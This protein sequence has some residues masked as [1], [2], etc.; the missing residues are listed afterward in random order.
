MADEKIYIYTLSRNNIP[1]YVGA[2]T[3]I[4]NRKKSHKHYRSNESGY[5]F[6][7]IDITLDE[8]LEQYWVHQLQSWGFDLENRQLILGGYIVDDLHKEKIRIQTKLSRG[9]KEQRLISSNDSKKRYE[10]IEARKKHSDR[11]KLWWAERKENGHGR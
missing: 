4:Y 3:N 2:T 10:S 1:F 9:T 11:M 7:V 8:S 5:T 6:D